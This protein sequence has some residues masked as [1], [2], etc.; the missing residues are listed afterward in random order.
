MNC[1]HQ[2]KCQI[3]KKNMVSS[4]T[5]N[6]HNDKASEDNWGLTNRKRKAM[7]NY[8]AEAGDIQTFLATKRQLLL[9]ITWIT[10]E[11]LIPLGWEKEKTTIPNGLEHWSDYNKQVIQ[12]QVHVTIIETHSARV[13]IL[14]PAL[15]F[16]F[17]LC[18]K[19]QVTIY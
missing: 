12:K 8:G 9:G 17:C 3:N 11:D 7:G 14:I 16:T 1:D 4:G 6:N 5:C 19:W 2:E 18:Y 10:W 13:S 15:R